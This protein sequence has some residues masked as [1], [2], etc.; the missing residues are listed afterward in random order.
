M[1]YRLKPSDLEKLQEVG[2]E[3]LVH[4]FGEIVGFW[5]GGN[6]DA[7]RRARGMMCDF[8]NGISR[9]LDPDNHVHLHDDE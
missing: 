5:M 7:Y 8:L 9:E 4:D 1:T 3:N 6:E 2:F